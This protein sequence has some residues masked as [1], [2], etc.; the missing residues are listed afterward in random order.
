MF[1][2]RG[3]LGRDGE[4][5]LAANAVESACSKVTIEVEKAQKATGVAATQRNGD[6]AAQLVGDYA[7]ATD[8]LAFATDI[9]EDV[10]LPGLSCVG[11]DRHRDLRVIE[12]LLAIAVEAILQGE[13]RG[14]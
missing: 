4:E 12:D 8:R 6:D 3:C 1:D 14:T 7:L 9:P 11:N 2:K 13:V 5:D 10:L